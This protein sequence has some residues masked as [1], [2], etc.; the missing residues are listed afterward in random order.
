MAKQG[1]KKKDL[2]RAV[3]KV[4][5][6]SSISSKELSEETPTERIEVGFPAEKLTLVTTGNLAATVTPKI[7]VANSNTG[8]AATT[9]P[10]TTTTTNMFSAV[11]ISWVS[12]A[13]KVLLLAK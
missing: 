6:G 11:E 10:S 1:Y 4:H 9:T 8:I 13:G 2:Q 3:Q 5:I 7:G 12:G